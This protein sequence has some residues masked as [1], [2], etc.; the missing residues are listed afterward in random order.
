M[1]SLV[2]FLKEDYS[3]ENRQE[4][5]YHF[6]VSEYAVRAQLVNGGHLGRDELQTDLCDMEADLEEAA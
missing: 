5:S 3:E 4:A 2:D 6:K 1:D